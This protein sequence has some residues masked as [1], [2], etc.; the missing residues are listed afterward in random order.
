MAV[1]KLTPRYL[2]KDNDPRVL[3]SIELVDALN[4]RVSNDDGGNAGVVKNI[5]G[6][7]VVAYKNTSDTLPAGTNKVIGHVSN[8][9]KDEV[10]YF[11]YNSNNNHS[12]YKYSLSSDRVIKVYQDSVLKFTENGF[13]KAD[14]IV[15]QY[16]DTL[17]YFTDGVTAPKKINISKAESGLYPSEYSQGT[18]PSTT[19]TEEERLYFITTAKQPPLDP[20]T[21]GFFTDS[22]K[23]VNNL[24]EKTFQF[25]Y[26]YIYD[27]G[28]VSAIS[29]YSSVAFTSDQLNDGFIAE[30][31][32]KKNNGVNV[33]VNT[34]VGD[35][36]KIRVLAR[37]GADDVFF[38]IDEI[39]ND[40]TGVLSK[41][42]KFFN[43]G[44]FTAVTQDQFNKL[45]DN[46]PI[47]A[48]TQAITGNRSTRS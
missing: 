37:S 2:N 14:I 6:N 21:W 7:T 33:Y 16:N 46:V 4:I 9:Q 40:R 8:L 5:K 35:V 19:L 43:D 3:K 20:P 17:L 18:N 31:A 22:S 25:A 38:I 10:F 13:V 36:K 44:S 30:D 39:D 45:F 41:T 12:I 23:T 42:V 28:E 34:H 29:P 24:Y 11:V 32:K 15:N 47:K 27:D 1:D 48:D 26:Q